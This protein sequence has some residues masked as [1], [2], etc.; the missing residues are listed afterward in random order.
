MAKISLT[1]Y[2]T[3]GDDVNTG[4]AGNDVIYAQ[5]GNDTVSGGDGNDQIYGGSGNDILNGGAGNDTLNGGDDNDVINGGTGSNILAGGYG[6]DTF[7]L[8]DFLGGAL[9]TIAD[10]HSGTDKLLVSSALP[11]GAIAAANFV[12]GTAALDAN[13]FFVYDRASGNLYFD[14][15]GSGAGAQVLV[16]TLLGQPDLKYTDILIDHTI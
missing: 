7:V 1:Q 8:A 12:A 15:D 4:T 3:D 5:G 14:A 13:D 2:L 16:A 11:E 6:A 10:F 9:N